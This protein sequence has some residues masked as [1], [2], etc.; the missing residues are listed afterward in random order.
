[1]KMNNNGLIE[2]NISDLHQ[3]IYTVE[4]SNSD[5]GKIAKR[6]MVK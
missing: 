5:F 2:L 1:M 6:F 4:I 3:G